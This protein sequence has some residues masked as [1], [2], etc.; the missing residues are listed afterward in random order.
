M[1]GGD[2]EGECPGHTLLLSIYWNIIKAY[3]IVGKTRKTHVFFPSLFTR[4]HFR[5]LSEL[6]TLSA[7]VCVCINLFNHDVTATELEVF[8]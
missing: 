2:G 7:A 8:I 6:S 5:N 3:K 1:C 4:L